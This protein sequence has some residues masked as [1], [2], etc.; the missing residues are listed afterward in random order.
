MREPPVGSSGAA[1]GDSLVNVPSAIGRMARAAAILAPMRF[2]KW[3]ALG[4]DYIVLEAD[5]VPFEL[6][7]ERIR[8]ICA[9]HFGCHSDGIL[10]LSQAR[11]P[12]CA[13][14]RAADLQPR[15][16]GGRA[17]RQRRPRGGPLPARAGLDRPRHLHDPDRRR[18]DH[19]DAR[20]ARIG[21]GRDGPGDDDLGRLPGRPDGRSRHDRRRRRRARVPARLD[22]QPA[23]RDRGRLDGLEDLDLPA[24][25]PAIERLAIFPNRTNVSFWRAEGSRVRARIFER[26]RGRDPLVGDRRDR[27]RGRRPPARGPE[28]D[29]RSCSTAASSRSRSAR[30]SRS[31]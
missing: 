9:P 25:G 23:V 22:R 7:P 13:R 5:D 10:L 8:A 3:Q 15:R 28:P 30:T 18:R 17:L 2:A 21:A 4:N 31:S 20:R 1:G 24:I 12:A 16:L 14:R 11:G 29:R 26:G 27:G 6:T 19:A